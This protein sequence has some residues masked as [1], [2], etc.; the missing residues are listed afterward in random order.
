MT[1]YALKRAASLL[2]EY[3]N[4]EIISNIIDDYPNKIEEKYF[5]NFENFNKII[6]IDIDK[7]ENQF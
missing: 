1:E 5:I 3:Y 2:K 7:L 4:V 6:G